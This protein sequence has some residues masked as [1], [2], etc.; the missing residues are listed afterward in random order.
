MQD[1]SLIQDIQK[2]IKLSDMEKIESWTV[3]ERRDMEINAKAM[4]TLICA[5]CLK[6]FNQV[7]TC[8]TAKEMWDK[9]KVTH[10]GINQV[11][12]TKINILV[13]EYELFTME[14]N[15]T[16][17]DMYTRFNDI[18]STL[19]ALGKSYTNGEKVRKILRNLPMSWDPKV[20]AIT[21]AKD[22][23]KLEF[24]NLLGSLMTH[25]IMMKRNDNVE[26]KKDKNVGFKVKNEEKDSQESD[27]DEF[28]LLARRFMKN[29]RFNQRRSFKKDKDHMSAKR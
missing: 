23:D 7:L 25:E 18:V 21:K 5:L 15:E 24:D 1:S 14:K 8:K 22:L 2:Q 28:A 26:P 16:I 6:E 29:G 10:E 3:E 27:D 12:E 13:H 11:K 4:N 20:T 19:E 9:L 17:K